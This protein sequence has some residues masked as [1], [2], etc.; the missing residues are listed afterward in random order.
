M[1][2]SYKVIHTLGGS[3]ISRLTR[4]VSEDLLNQLVLALLELVNYGVV[5]RILVLL[6]PATDVVGNLVYKYLYEVLWL[7]V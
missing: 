1:Y 3:S 5:K 6:K 2:S 4:M 7:S